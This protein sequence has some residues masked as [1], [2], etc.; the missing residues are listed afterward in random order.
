MSRI[1]VLAVVSLLLLAGCTGMGGDSA[2]ASGQQ[3]SGGAGGADVAQAG[4]GGGGVA[5]GQGAALAQVDPSSTDPAIVRTG[6]MELEVE[7]FSESRARISTQV[8]EY[9][10]YVNGSDRRLHRTGDRRWV[11]GTLVLRVPSD[12]YS[13]MQSDIREHGTVVQERTETRDVS[14]QLV[15]LE[16]RLT[17]LRERRDRLRTFYQEA[18]GTEELLAIEAELS[19]VQGEIERLEAR[20]RSLEQQVAYS[21]IRVEL[22]EDAPGPQQVN[23]PFH[24]QSLVGTFLD[25]VGTL[26]V[27]GRTLLVAFVAA[28]PWL[29][30]AG[31]ALLGLRRA[32]GRIGIPFVGGAESELPDESDGPEA[33]ADSGDSDDTQETATS[34]VTDR[35]EE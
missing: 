26:Y 33:T 7:N 23:T 21:T 34:H 4:D 6:Y 32:L 8:R 3:S 29:G 35:P 27:A 18:N 25:S 12:S 28:S 10:G 22:R 16:A 17:N 13:D 2:G 9:G 30:V 15:D 31:V 11:T 1:R 19:E 5:D 24:Q 20:Q 14:D